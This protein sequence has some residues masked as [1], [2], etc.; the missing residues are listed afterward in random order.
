[1]A[2]LLFLTSSV[3]VVVL[4]SAAG[5]EYQ[6]DD[7]G[8]VFVKAGEV[9]KYADERLQAAAN[10]KALPTPPAIVADIVTVKIGILVTMSYE[11]SLIALVLAATRQSPAAAL[12]TFRMDRYRW[13]GIWRPALV[14]L[15][16]Y[17]GITVYSIVM[18]AIG[19]GW[20]EPQ[21]TIPAAI[22]R[23]DT[24]LALAGLLAVVGAPLAEETF[25]RGFVFGGLSRWG[26]WPAAAISALL[27][28]LVHFDPGSIIPFFCIGLALAWI[29]WSRGSLW[30][31][32][33][34]HAMF[35]GTSFLILLFSR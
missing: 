33:A 17:V 18:S 6:F 2:A 8:D 32:V 26:F 20:L 5:R 14:C 25:F 21:S 22:V 29:F 16:A 19:I 35:N 3:L 13:S 23:N 7:V 27:F 12:R 30:D 34:L 31:N 28:T 10:G 1:M 4:V 15:G 11:L 24:A 9:G